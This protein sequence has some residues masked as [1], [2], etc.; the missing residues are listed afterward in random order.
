MRVLTLHIRP[1]GTAQYLARVFDGKVL[2]GTPTLH[3]EIDEA[4]EAYGHA[5]GFP[6]VTAFNIWYGG[7]SVGTVP[8]IQMRTDAVELSNRLVVLSA[9]LR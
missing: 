4:I 3:A 7:G 6:G 5:D 8:L 2:V 1:E 9:V